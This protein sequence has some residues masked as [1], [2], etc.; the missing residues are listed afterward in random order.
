MKCRSRPLADIPLAERFMTQPIAEAVREVLSQGRPD[1]AAAIIQRL[2]PGAAV[3]V[4]TALSFEEQQILFRRL[5]VDFA[6][7]LVSH[8]HYYHEYVLLHSRPAAEMRTIVDKLDPTERIQFFD[9]LPEEAWQRLMDELA[10]APAEAPGVAPPPGVVPV[11]PP[12]AA[13]KIIEARHVEKSFQQ[14]DVREIQVIAPLDLLRGI[15]RHHRAPRGFSLR[16]IYAV[17]D[18][19]RTRNA[20]RRR[21]PV[22][23]TPA[24]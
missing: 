5:P 10:V 14:P 1:E 4:F 13:E 3:G 21:C 7:A 6:A 24:V 15:Q 20:I 23:R 9:E 16:Q 19:L 22:A 11:P 18:P 2:E 12:P 8:F 17:A